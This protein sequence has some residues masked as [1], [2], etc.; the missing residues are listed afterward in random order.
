MIKQ[1][2]R[3]LWLKQIGLGV[4]GVGLANF[5]SFAASADELATKPLNELAI[6]LSSNESP[7]GPSPLAKKAMSDYIGIS[8]RYNWQ[9]TSELLN[10]IAIQLNVTADNILMGAGSTEMLDLVARFSAL[11]KG[12]LIIAEPSFA[13]WTDAAQKLGLKKITVSLTAEK[14]INLS[15]MLSAIRPDTKLIY[16]CNPN[17]PT[18]TVCDRDKLI[19]FISEA[20]KKAIVLVDEAYIEYT[21]QQSLSNIAIE[22]ENLIITKTFSKIY[23]LAGARVGYA[24]ANTKTIEKLGE[25]QSWVNGSVSVAS[26]A[27]ALASLGDTKFRLE[28]YALNEKAKHFTIEQLVKLNLAC[29]PSYSNFIYFS[30]ENCKKDFFYQLKTNNI[31]GT[32]I[33]E[34]KGKWTRISVGT[35]SEMK[36]F[37]SAIE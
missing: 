17:N 35:M 25:L 20:T 24:V 26:T 15:G 23:G 7:Y 8:N 2:K 28:T 37:I 4:A 6:R 18:G 12:S 36:K 9:L 22:N 5:K 21:D 32:K 29:I 14:K 33:Y 1:T 34:E 13:Y 11:Q 30:L 3:R 19:K 10:A 16:L 31:I 27:A